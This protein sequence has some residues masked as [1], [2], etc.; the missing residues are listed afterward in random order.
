MIKQR[1]KPYTNLIKRFFIGFILG[2]MPYFTSSLFI[3]FDFGESC[4]EASFIGL[5][6]GALVMLFGKRMLN[7]LIALLKIGW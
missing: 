5:L 3:S 1:E 4:L 7:I 2:A 6:T